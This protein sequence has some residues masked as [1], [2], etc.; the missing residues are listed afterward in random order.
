M[1]LETV[2]APRRRATMRGRIRQ[3]PGRP[4]TITP[5]SRPADMNR[6]YMPWT[7]EAEVCSKARIATETGGREAL[8][9]DSSTSLRKWP[10][11]CRLDAP[12]LFVMPRKGQSWRTTKM[13]RYRNDLPQLYDTFITDGGLETTMIFHEGLDLP[14]F[15]TV[16]MLRDEAGRDILRRYYLRYIELARAHRVGILLDTATW[17]ASPDW[18]WSLGCDAQELAGLNRRAVE[19]LESI[20]QTHASAT[21]PIV[22]SAQ[23]GPRGDGYVADLRMSAS[24]ARDYHAVQI[25]TFAATSAD[26][27]SAYTLNYVDEAIGI[28]EAAR[29]HAMPVAISFTV[30]TDALLPSG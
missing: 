15:A 13:S 24:Q 20:R 16:V 22:V 21:T 12:N 7:T 29:D 2:S 27:V 5:Q 23:L 14:H 11:T 26:L 18:G 10:S 4:S 6:S 17:R 3:G 28:V 25:G 1:P 9:A 30:E 8:M 19:L